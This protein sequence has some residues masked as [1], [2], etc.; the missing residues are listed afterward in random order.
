MIA[1]DKLA[2]LATPYTKYLDGDIN[3]A[4]DEAARLAGLL[5]LTGIQIYSPIV[6]CHPIALRAAIDPLN[7]EFWL[8]NQ[9][10]MMARSDVL[11][12][13]EI[14]GWQESRGIAHEIKTFRATGK[15]VFYCNPA[16]LL[17]QREGTP[18]LAHGK[19]RSEQGGA[20]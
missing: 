12:V 20:P 16:T 14:E 8:A 10:I 4:F 9:A 7:V 19:T 6:H 13:A 2:Y 11:I 3:A 1:T 5:M 18:Q 17:M 15:P